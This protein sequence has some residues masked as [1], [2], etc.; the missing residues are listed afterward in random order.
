MTR[1]SGLPLGLSLHLQWNICL[2]LL[3]SVVM[4]TAAWGTET[5][6]SRQVLNKA[7]QNSAFSGQWFLSYLMKDEGDDLT[8]HFT[9]K[10]GYL[11]FTKE[12]SKTLSIRFTQDITLDEEGTDAGN[13][14]MRLKYCYLKINTHAFPLLRDGYVEVGLVHRP[15]LDFE[16]KINR[17]RV[18]GMMFLERQR[19]MNSADFGFTFVNLLGGKLQSEYRKGS[20]ASLPGRYGSFAIGIYNGGG[21]HAIEN[22]RNKTIEGRISIRPLPD[23]IPGFQVSYHGVRGKG[24]TGSS[25][26]FKV[27]HAFVSFENNFLSLTAQQVWGNGNAAGTFVNE[28]GAAILTSGMSFFG[29][30]RYPSS[31]F[32]VFSRWDDFHANTGITSAMGGIAY[33]FMNDSKA[34][35]QIDRQSTDGQIRWIY[36]LAIE[37]KF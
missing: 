1:L 7:L 24:N 18:Q 16:E 32:A 26:V 29:E 19:I 2:A 9:L 6:T 13:I 4:S 15:W 5:D 12:F 22:N 34:I 31:G 14:E 3:T 17:Y 11:T 28:A 33:Y 25:P 36:E 35:A 30:L 10:R 21:Y 20:A 27:D 8:S 37:L 23:H